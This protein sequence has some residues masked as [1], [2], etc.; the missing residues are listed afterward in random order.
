[1]SSI[2]IHPSTYQRAI[3]IGNILGDGSLEFNGHIGTRLQIKQSVR[4]KEYVLWL[5]S[6]LSDLCRS[7]PKQKTDTGQWYFSTRALREFTSFWKIFYQ[8]GEKIVPQNIAELLISP[9]SLAVWYMDDG[10][11]DYRPKDHCSIT[12]HTDSFS[13]ENV[14]K[15]SDVLEK[16]FGIVAKQM[17]SLCRGKRYAK[18]YIGADGRKR[19]FELVRPYMLQCFARKLPPVS[20]KI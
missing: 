4:H 17:S 14:E 13:T 12:L 2:L 15:L 3:I 1:M 11:L 19:F 18:L 8:K 10:A 7:A 6:K 9:L 5:Y 20:Y 16:N